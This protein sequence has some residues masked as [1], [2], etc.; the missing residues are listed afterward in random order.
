MA[1]SK[2]DKNLAYL[3]SPKDYESRDKGLYDLTTSFENN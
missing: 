1:S 2:T 3:L